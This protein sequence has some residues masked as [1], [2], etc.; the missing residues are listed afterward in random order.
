MCF[1]NYNFQTQGYLACT[2]ESVAPRILK[3]PER[4]ER[5]GTKPHYAIQV[6]PSHIRFTNSPSANFLCQHFFCLDGS[7][8]RPGTRPD[9]NQHHDW[10][11]PQERSVEEFQVRKQCKSYI[12]QL[13]LDRLQNPAEIK[14]GFTKIFRKRE[15]TYFLTQKVCR[16]GENRENPLKYWTWFDMF[17]GK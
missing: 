1:C 6:H 11:T 8:L 10:R 2:P 16:N 14:T 17:P 5:A 12:K 9:D 7:Y 13:F 3:N 4:T 15:M